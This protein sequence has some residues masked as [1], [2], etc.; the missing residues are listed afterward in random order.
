MLK[1]EGAPTE[2]SMTWRIKPRSGFTMVELV[3]ELN[4]NTDLRPLRDQLKGTVVLH[5]GELRRINSSGTR[6]WINFIRDLPG[7]TEITLTHC[8]PAVVQ[9]LNSIHNFR[10][11]ATVRSVMVPYTCESCFAHEEKLLNVDPGPALGPPALPLVDCQKCNSPMEF[12][13][14]A[15]RYFE[16]LRDR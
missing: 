7:V 16:F 15:E 5:L 13:E 12:E 1:R 2:H 4:E 10:G 3:G 9:Q 14:L 8:S 11:K 6:E